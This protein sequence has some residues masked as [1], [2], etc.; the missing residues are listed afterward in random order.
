M[1]LLDLIECLPQNELEKCQLV[2]VLWYKNVSKWKKKWCRFRTFN[3]M[4]I[5]ERPYSCDPYM[6]EVCAD[7]YRK[8]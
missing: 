7:Y 6:E 8:F 3:E 4:F 5:E 1:I 2:C